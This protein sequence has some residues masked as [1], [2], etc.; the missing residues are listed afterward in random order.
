VLNNTFV[1][2]SHVQ[3]VDGRVVCDLFNADLI[4]GN[5]A[6]VGLA[7]DRVERFGLFDV[8]VGDEWLV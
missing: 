4:V 8:E 7:P 6:L 5:G 1:S 3:H 2:V